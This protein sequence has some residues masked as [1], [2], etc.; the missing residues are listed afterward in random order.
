MLWPAGGRGCAGSILF[1][2]ALPSTPPLAVYF[3]T[4]GPAGLKVVR[5]GGLGGAGGSGGERSKLDMGQACFLGQNSG[6]TS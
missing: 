3:V 1:S 6:G 2:P 4:P 5:L